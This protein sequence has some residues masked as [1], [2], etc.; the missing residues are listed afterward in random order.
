MKKI[1]Y[2]AGLFIA[3]F[4]IQWF[5]YTQ[6]MTKSNKTPL[7]MLLASFV[8]IVIVILLDFVSVKRRR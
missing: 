6:I 2:Y 1:L 7:D 4:A 8:F 5:W 3:C